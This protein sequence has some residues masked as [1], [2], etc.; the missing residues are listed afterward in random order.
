ME[1]PNQASGRTPRKGVAWVSQPCILATA[2]LVGS[3]LGTNG[4]QREMQGLAGGSG[5]W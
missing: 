1:F 3:M 5:D 4:F 2:S